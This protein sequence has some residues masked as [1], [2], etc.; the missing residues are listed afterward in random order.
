MGTF[1]FVLRT[2]F[3]LNIFGTNFLLN[4]LICSTTIFSEL[5]GCIFLQNTLKCFQTKLK[6][7][8]LYEHSKTFTNILKSA[9]HLLG[10]FWWPFLR[11]TLICSQTIWKVWWTF[12]GNFFGTH[13]FGTLWN[14]SKF[15]NLLESEKHFLETFL[16]NTLNCSQTNMECLKHYKQSEL[17][18]EHFLE[19][20]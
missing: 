4:I 13:F 17:F 16:R 20:L 5:F 7:F 10:T 8:K 2:I 14:V 19:L 3:L 18:D 6:C 1:C 11:N 12:F 15:L 9:K